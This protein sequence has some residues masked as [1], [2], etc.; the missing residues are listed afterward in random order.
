MIH[1]KQ[2]NCLGR[3]PLLKHEICRINPMAAGVMWYCCQTHPALVVNFIMTS[4][5]IL[6]KVYPTWIGKFIMTCYGS[7]DI[8]A[9]CVTLKVKL[10]FKRSLNLRLN[11]ACICINV[12]P[13][14]RKLHL[15]KCLH[16]GKIFSCSSFQCSHL[17]C[18][19]LQKRCFSWMT[20]GSQKNK[21]LQLWGPNLVCQKS[22]H[23]RWMSRLQG[24]KAKGI[25]GQRGP[26]A[27]TWPKWSIQ[28]TKL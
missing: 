8:L 27:M 28:R 4:Y 3:G 12:S 7:D 13:P 9:K 23:L 14:T 5:A 16:R 20:C 25:V 1:S 11:V 26:W 22:Q 24:K 15:T 19:L 21:S 10:D 6:L 17:G 18:Q 2:R